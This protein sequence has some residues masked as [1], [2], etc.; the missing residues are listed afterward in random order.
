MNTY[1]PAIGI[2]FNSLFN[3]FGYSPSDQR[4]YAN[5]YWDLP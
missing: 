2:A 5:H 4:V 3:F 1:K